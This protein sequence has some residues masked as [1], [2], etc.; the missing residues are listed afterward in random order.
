MCP[1]LSPLVLASAWRAC[2]VSLPSPPESPEQDTAAPGE[3]PDRSAP[4]QPPSV[5]SGAKNITRDLCPNPKRR[6]CPAG[7]LLPALAGLGHS[8]RAA[9][10]HAPH[11]QQTPAG[12]WALCRLRKEGRGP[13]NHSSRSPK[14]SVSVSPV[15]GGTPGLPRVPQASSR[16]GL[17]PSP[18]A[19]R[20]WA[21]CGASAEICLPAH[22]AVSRTEG[23]C[24]R[25]WQRHTEAHSSLESLAPLRPPL[26]KVL[27]L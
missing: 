21:A 13:P 17:P 5:Q 15:A 3:W 2:Q 10:S 12:G 16:A 18:G 24:P 14:S 19:P 25:H 11:P 23:P 6:W 1:T 27:C 9:Q 7:R 22:A 26:D 20:A 4:P 8:P